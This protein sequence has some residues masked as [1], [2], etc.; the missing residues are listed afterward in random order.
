MIREFLDGSDFHYEVQEKAAKTKIDVS[1]AGSDIASNIDP[2][3]LMV[4]IEAMHA[5]PHRTRNYTRYMPDCLKNSVPTW[6]K[7]YCRPLIKHHNEKDG[8]IIGRVIDARYKTHD[9]FSGTPALELTVNVPGEEAKQEVKNGISQTVSI[10]VMADDVRCSIC[11]AQL[12]NGEWCEHE[13]G[14]VYKNERTGEME[15]CCWDIYSMEAKELSYVIVPSDMYAKNVRSYPASSSPN[16]ALSESFDGHKQS[17]QEGEQEQMADS[18]DMEA[19]LQEAQ[20]KVED[21]TKKL[22]EMTEAAEGLKKQIAELTESQ[23]QSK[24][25]IE[26]LESEKTELDK[27][28]KDL[29]ESKKSLEDEKAEELKLKESLEKD[30][31]DTKATLKESMIDKLQMLRKA[32]G[33]L[34]LD[35]EKVKARTEASIMDSIEDLKAELAQ[36]EQKI[37]E[38][39]KEQEAK[40]DPKNLPEPES[41]K[42]EALTEEADEKKSAAKD[43][44]ENSATSN[45]DLK[46][47]LESIFND[48]VTAH[49]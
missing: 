5:A 15:E 45:I 1:E 43:V 9:T 46:A 34:E 29:T 48:V 18:K 20:S 31:A 27:S 23:E 16:P 12:S 33:K 35:A 30:L 17:S 3:S 8:K 14:E 10:G 6:T 25:Q 19:K 26:T 40:L 42:S 4:D 36:K 22:A 13:R 21:L 39:V 11:G 2:N 32:T 38:S 7:P 47:G 37:A 41:V 28:V 44:K 49:R 24:K